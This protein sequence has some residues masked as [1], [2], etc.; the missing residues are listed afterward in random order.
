MAFEHTLRDE[1]FGRIA[2]TEPRRDDLTVVFNACELRSGSAFRFGSE[3]SGCWRIGR[4]VDNDVPLSLAVAASAAYPVILPAIDRVFRFVNRK[5][6]ELSKRVFLTDGGVFENLGVTCLEPGRS[7]DFSYHTYCPEYIICCDA[8]QGLYGDDV[9]PYH[10]A[11]RMQRS[12]ET[13]YR[14]AH[15]HIRQRLHAYVDSGRLKGFV[16]SYLGQM[17][18]ALPLIPPDLVRREQVY[19]Y[20]TD[21][22]PMSERDIELL[23]TRGEQ[24]TRLLISRYCP[25][26]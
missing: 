20:P 11:S 5:G 13:I 24:L 18:R 26:L 23:T 22:S 21:F 9:Y 15:D 1:L 14:K 19:K 8:G 16:L 2:I 17:D 12:F 4:L 25:E 10:W 3:A 7:A 6:R